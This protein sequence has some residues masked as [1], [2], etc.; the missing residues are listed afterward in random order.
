MINTS[1][2]A[3]AAAEHVRAWLVEHR[4]GCGGVGGG[5]GGIRRPIYVVAV[6]ALTRDASAVTCF[7][8]RRLVSE[9]KAN[10]DTE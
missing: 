3:A 6:S 9:K 5:V 4:D 10:T 2:S 8:T 7:S 1:G